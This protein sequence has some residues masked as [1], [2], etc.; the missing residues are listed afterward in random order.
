MYL[1]TTN[2]AGA[3]GDGIA[4][5][6]RA[7]AQ[8][9]D[10]EFYQFH[11][12]ALA[13]P[14]T[15][16][17]SEAVRGEGAVLAG[18]RMAAGSCKRSIL[19]L[20]S[21]LVMLWLAGLRCKWRRR[22]D[23]QFF[24]TRPTWVQSFWLGGF[25]VSMPHAVA[26]G[27]NWANEPIPVTPAAHYWMGGVRTDLWG[28]TSVPGLFAVGEAA[29]TGVHGA[30]RLASNS[31][32]ESLVFAWRCAD[33]LT[34]KV[35]PRGQMQRQPHRIEG[36]AELPLSSESASP[37]IQLSDREQLQSLMWNMVGIERNGHDLRK[38]TEQL[39]SWHDG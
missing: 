3:T 1:H 8:L 12:T 33:L 2:P 24:W 26:R 38:R 27:L 20:N 15:F 14:G 9:A 6:L 13:V 21:H 23:S 35:R 28:R 22:G 30:N 34:E 17:V 18:Q 29:C 7:G 25:P 4:M 31:L 11:P 32:L 16:L 36:A 5:A 10:V 19:T 39:N 37:P